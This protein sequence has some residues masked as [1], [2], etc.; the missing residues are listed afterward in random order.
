MFSKGQGGCDLG[1]GVETVNFVPNNMLP[2]HS[3]HVFKPF[4][5]FSFLL[6]PN[7]GYGT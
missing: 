7:L 6:C 2:F 1:K 5:C 4:P 3:H